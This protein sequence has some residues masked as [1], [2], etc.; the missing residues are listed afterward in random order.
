MVGNIAFRACTLSSC[1][2]FASAA[3]ERNCVSFLRARAIASESVIVTGGLALSGAAG[4]I[5]C[6]GSLSLD[7]GLSVTACAAVGR[8]KIHSTHTTKLN[9]HSTYSREFIFEL[10]I[11]LLPDLDLQNWHTDPIFRLKP[12]NEN[13]LKIKATSGFRDPVRLNEH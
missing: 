2:I 9:A 13:S 12:K 5:S 8:G 6:N 7:C 3:T 11:S 4:C 10:N 1:E